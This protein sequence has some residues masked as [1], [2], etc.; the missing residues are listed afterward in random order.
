MG[1]RPF[2]S[3]DEIERLWDFI[4]KLSRRS[5]ER[6]GLTLDQQHAINDAAAKFY[7]AVSNSCSSLPD[8]IANLITPPSGVNV[9]EG[10]WAAFGRE[11]LVHMLGRKDVHSIPEAYLKATSVLKVL[12]DSEIGNDHFLFRGQTNIEW[13]VIPRL[14]RQLS[15]D[16]TWHPPKDYL[17]GTSIT[18]VLNEEI[19]ALRK[20]QHTWC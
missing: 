9:D 1:I 8:G 11:E 20:F 3:K 18:S 2:Q 14:G 12:R 4:D 15:N 19:D 6:Q 5:W 7:H 10:N 17:T 13:E 16:A